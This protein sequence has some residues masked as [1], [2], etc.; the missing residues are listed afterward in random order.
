VAQPNQ[1]TV[2]LPHWNEEFPW[3]SFDP[4]WYLQHN[5]GQLRDDDHEI[6]HDL[7]DFFND[8]RGTRLMH[9]IDVGTG[10][11]L[12]PVLAMLP[13]CGSITL[14]ERAKTNCRWLAFETARYSRLWDPFWDVLTRRPLYQPI[15]DPRWAVHERTRVRRGSIFDLARGAYDIGTMFF[16]AESITERVDEFHR[17][18]RCFL[19]SLRPN[20]PFAAAFMRNSDGYHVNGVRF[21]AVPITEDDVCRCLAGEGIRKATVRRIDSAHPLRDGVG[22]VLVTGRVARR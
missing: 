18:V 3:D 16:V 15:Q 1:D 12:Y 4:E 7:A 21:P 6:L 9:G 20:A 17:A 13:L 2:V 5:Y 10:S 14:H 8:V 22:M 11:N 19:R